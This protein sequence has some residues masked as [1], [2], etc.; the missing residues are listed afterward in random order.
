MVFIAYGLN[1]KTAPLEMREKFAL[2]SA[3]HDV[4]LSQLLDT[5]MAEEAALLS[6]CNRTEIYCDTSDPE[7]LM[8]WFA[9]E[10]GLKPQTLSPHCYLHQA[11]HGIRH[12]LRVASGLDSMMLGEPQILGQMKE[13]FQ[14]ACNLGTIKTNLRPIFEYVFQASKRIRTLSG[15]GTNPLSVAYAAAQLV[16]QSFLNPHELCVFLIGSG[17]TASLVASYLQKQGIHHF[18]VASRTQENAAKLAAPFSG[19]PVSIND[20]AYYLPKADVIISATACPLPFITK[21]LVQQTLA[22]RNNKPLFFLDLAVPRDIEANVAELANVTLYNIDDLQIKIDHNL[23]QRQLAAIEAEQL[24]EC[25]LDNYIR[26]HRGI[27]AKQI[28]C[29]YRQTMYSLAKLELKRSM[30]QL[31]KGTNQEQVLEELCYRLV[32]KLTHTPSVG[33]RQAAVDGHDNLLTLVNYLYT[34]PED[35]STHEEIA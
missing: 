12:T 7:R 16:K 4:L 22:L 31:N 18:F 8:A 3:R 24:I 10:H 21:N 5:A 11:H 32:N 23:G 19:I 35:Q 2:S 26:W 1:H 30:T 27:N 15:I 6:T 29:N 34:V 13:A 20:I 9:D 17:E 25:E 14:K 33:L 28:I